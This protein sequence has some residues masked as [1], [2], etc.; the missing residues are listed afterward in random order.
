MK[1]IVFKIVV[2]SLVFATSSG[3]AQDNINSFLKNQPVIDVHIHITKGY[4][5]NEEYNKVN[6][7]IDIHPLCE[8][9]RLRTI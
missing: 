3:I 4:E 2:W 9:P 7:D 5:D 8:V 1:H 6:T